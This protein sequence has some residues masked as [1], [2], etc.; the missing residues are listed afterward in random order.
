MR[1]KEFRG[2]KDL[3]G[4]GEGGGA[5]KRPGERLFPLRVH[6]PGEPRGRVDRPKTFSEGIGLVGVGRGRRVRPAFDHVPNRL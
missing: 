2:R 1:W 6:L 5:G 4:V 3:T